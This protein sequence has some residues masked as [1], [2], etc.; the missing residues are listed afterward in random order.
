MYSVVCYFTCKQKCDEHALYDHVKYEYNKKYNETYYSLKT[1]HLC[2]V[3]IRL[4][5]VSFFY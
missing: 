1:F 4:Q 2:A 3:I 5:S